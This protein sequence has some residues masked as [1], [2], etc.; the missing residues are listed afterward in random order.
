[1]EF[2][3]LVSLI[4]GIAEVLLGLVLLPQFG[5][6]GRSFPWLI[7]LM[8]FFVVGGLDR[9]YTGAL[10]R[11]PLI[12]PAITDAVS[13]ALVA[14]LI[15]GMRRTALALRSSIEDARWEKDEYE[16]ALRDFRIL[17]RHR[18]AN[19][20]AV[21]VAG[22]ETLRRSRSIPE[23]E[24]ETILD[25]MYQSVKRLTRVSVDAEPASV[26]EEPLH[27]KPRIDH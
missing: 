27:P 19:P 7:A 23:Q 22:I 10:G 2:E 25:A 9:V 1:M 21:I 20:L 13:L 18:L 17:V 8:A 12:A 11:E 14:L 5:R 6:L 15:F 4:L 16:R 3:S 24:E 26:E